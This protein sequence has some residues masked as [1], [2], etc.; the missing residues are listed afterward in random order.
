MQKNHLIKNTIYYSIGEILPRV[1]SFIMLPIYTR[2]LSPVDYGI[3]SYTQT[4]IVFLYVLGA[5]SLNSYVLRYYFIHSEEWDRKVL[6]GT[7]QLAIIFL[8]LII[9]IAAFF[10]MPHIISNYG[11]QIPWDPYFKIAFIVNLLDSLS[12]IPFVIYR[13]RQDAVKFVTLG[14]TR[15]FL[16]VGLTVYFVC[17]QDK[18]VL[19]VFLAQLYVIIPFA[20]IYLVV[21]NH[22]A[23]WKFRFDYLMEGIRFSAPLIPGSICFLLLSVS[24]RVILERH[25]GID[26]LGIYNVACQISLALNIVI[27]SGYKAIEP[28][29]FRRYGTE[30]FYDFIGKTQRF[31]FCTIYIGAFVLCLFAQEVFFLMTSESFYKGYM[32]VPALV[33]GVIMTGQN[34]IY[35]GILQGERR[36]KVL[37]AATMV[38]AI[39][40]V[41][42]NICLIPYIGTY[43]AAFASAFSFFVMNTILFYKMTYPGKTMIRETSLVLLVPALAYYILYLSEEVSVK[44]FIVK[45]LA[46]LLYSFFAL[47][48]LDVKVDQLKNLLLIKKV[49]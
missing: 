48:L 11:I 3:I 8:N 10:S 7:V 41:S 1:I 18:G 46:V 12:I 28:E 42:L 14:L 25:V 34:V 33:V 30:G 9:F 15:T 31:F 16:T 17:F 43:A 37:G 38:G 23:T 36:T 29:L 44:G 27:Q 2:Y 13:V 5:F 20:L 21:M 26:E 24:D 45:V 22:Y 32:L 35:G 49:L 47:K 39:V 40:S 19:G 6:L 4:I